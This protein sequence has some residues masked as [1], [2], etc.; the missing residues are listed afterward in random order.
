MVSR[1]SWNSVVDPGKTVG[2]AGRLRLVCQANKHLVIQAANPGGALRRVRIA[3]ILTDTANLV[4]PFRDVLIAEIVARQVVEVLLGGFPIL[5][6]LG[7]P[8]GL[9]D[10]PFEDFRI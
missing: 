1:R 10:R 8:S 9:V 6:M 4:Q 3:V 5:E 7:D 2:S